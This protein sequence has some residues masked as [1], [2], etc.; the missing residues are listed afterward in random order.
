MEQLCPLMGGRKA[1]IYILAVDFFAIQFDIFFGKG[2]MFRLLHLFT[3]VVA[4]Y[5]GKPSVVVFLAEFNQN[6]CFS[7]YLGQSDLPR[8]L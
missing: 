5:H 3:L 7:C 2:N 1:Q 8:R 4:C 6:H